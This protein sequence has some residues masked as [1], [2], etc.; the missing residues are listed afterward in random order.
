MMS[1]GSQRQQTVSPLFYVCLCWMAQLHLASLQFS[2]T[3][4]ILAISKPSSLAV[5]KVTE[6]LSLAVSKVTEPSSL[7]VSKVTEPSSLAVREVL[8]VQQVMK[9]VATGGGLGTMLSAAYIASD[10]SWVEVIETN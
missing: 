5:S 2:A 7:A 1:G 10:T 9:A 3:A 4:F 6:P 8:L